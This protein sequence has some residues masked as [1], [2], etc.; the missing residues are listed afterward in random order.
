MNMC[1]RRRGYSFSPSWTKRNE[2]VYIRTTQ[3]FVLPFL[4]YQGRKWWLNTCLSVNKI[5]FASRLCRFFEWRVLWYRKVNFRSRKKI[6]FY[7][8]AKLAQAKFHWELVFGISHLSIHASPTGGPFL[9]HLMSLVPHVAFSPGLQMY[10]LL[11]P[12]KHVHFPSDTIYKI[13]ENDR[14]YAVSEE[15]WFWKSIY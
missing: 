8:C 9:W 1:V 15:S 6:F 5:T 10:L 11:I 12:T 7:L 2:N 14:I 13:E 3:L 4:S